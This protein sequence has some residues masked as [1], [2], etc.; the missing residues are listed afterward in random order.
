[1]NISQKL[2]SSFAGVVALMIVLSMVIWFKVNGLKDIQ[3][4]VKSDDVPG[5]FY[6]LQL[7]DEI[8]DLRSELLD[9]LAGNKE[10]KRIFIEDYQE[11]LSAYN[12]IV[13]LE[14]ATQSD[15]DK[16]AKIKRLGEEINRRAMAEV[17]DKDISANREAIVRVVRELEKTHFEVLEQIT[18]KSASEEQEDATRALDLVTQGMDQISLIIISITLIAILLSAFIAYNLG[19]SIRNKLN[20]VLER[21]RQIANG[22]LALPPLVHNNK[23]EIDSLAQAMNDMSQSLNKLIKNISELSG[24]VM[25]SATEITNTN[26][27]ITKRSIESSSQSGLIAT[28]IEEMSSTVAEVARQSRDASAHADGAQSLASE[29]GEVVRHTVEE[30]K[31]ASQEVQNT[32]SLVTNLGE[33]GAQIGDVIRVIGSIAEQTNLLALNAAIEAARAGEQGRGFA[34]V[35]DEVRTLAERTTQATG[36]VSTTVQAIQTQTQQAVL[37]M[38]TSVEKVNHSVELAEG[39]GGSLGSIEQSASEIATMIQS[40]ATATDEQTSVAT[41]MS[42]EIV[43]IDESS[44]LSLNDSQEAENIADRLTEQATQLNKLIAQFKVN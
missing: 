2:Y 22:N 8:G 11:F 35:A 29:G 40:I 30:I 21:S 27:N 37:S 15:R 18:D 34:V 13:P 1:M 43:K 44:K 28:A 23:D 7:L 36:E 17:F 38:Q 6:Y 39:A 14:S 12:Q 25:Q 41:N 26:S 3:Q 16:M 10:S 33:L 19:N 31:K 24:Y 32:A 9:Y 5:A 4:E 20:Q 42:H